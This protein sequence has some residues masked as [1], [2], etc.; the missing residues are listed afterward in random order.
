MKYRQVYSF[1]LHGIYWILTSGFKKHQSFRFLLKGKV[2]YYF[3]FS[4]SYI[5]FWEKE[6]S[7]SFFQKEIHPREIHFPLFWNYSY[8]SNFGYNLATAE[9]IIF[10]KTNGEGNFELKKEYREI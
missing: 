3:N 7:E 8:F 10:N 6:N 4:K 9:F 5:V 1:L 2:I